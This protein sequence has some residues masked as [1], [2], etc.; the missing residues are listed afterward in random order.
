MA[1]EINQSRPVTVEVNDLMQQG[2]RY[3]LTEPAGKNFDERFTPDLSPPELLKM[4]V[5][6]GK[7][8]TEIGRAHV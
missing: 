6:G 8:M 3:E 7:Y 1:Q 2:Y 5:F 4:G